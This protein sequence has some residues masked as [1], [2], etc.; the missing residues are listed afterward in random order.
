MLSSQLRKLCSYQMEDASAAGDPTILPHEADSVSIELWLFKRYGLLLV[1]V[2]S[3]DAHSRGIVQIPHM[4]ELYQ[5]ALGLLYSLLRI[6][7]PYMVE[8]AFAVWAP[9]A[10][11]Q[12]GGSFLW[13]CGYP[14]A[15]AY[16]SL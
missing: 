14:S 6:L 16:Q 8:D 7:Y 9:T 4:Q 10:A 1:P 12:E 2:I 3:P 5:I 11:P 13:R 15:M